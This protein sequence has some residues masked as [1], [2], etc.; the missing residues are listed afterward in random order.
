MRL[1]GKVILVTGSTSGI[2]LAIAQRA[3]TE[4]ARVL[5]HGMAIEEG[6][7]AAQRIGAAAR[8]REG[9]LTDPATARTLVACALQAFGRLD[10]LVNN[11]ACVAH[12]DV[13]TTSPEF[14]DRVMAVN[15]R[16]P[17]LLLHAALP[18]L[19]EAQGSVL[20]IGSVNAHCGQPDMLDYSVSK[21][22]LMTMTRN[23]A[24]ALGTAGVRVNQIN[25]GWVLTPNEDALQRRLGMKE[26]W[27][28]H[29]PEAYAPSGRLLE[30]EQIAA[31]AVYFLSDESR[32]VS[33][34]VVELEQFSVIGRNPPKVGGGALHG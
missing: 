16:A 29:V 34:S 17:L 22:A 1:A 4:G 14:F 20:N 23:L 11:A 28:R 18:V 10:C 26:G 6:K 3:V 19:R 21:G 9:D 25:P 15:V 5:L 24:N 33:G 12:S 8:F 7:A 27:H 31:A 2:G 30:P 13:N 32:P